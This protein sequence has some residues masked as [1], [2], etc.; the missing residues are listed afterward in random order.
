MVKIKHEWYGPTLSK[1]IL[2]IV[3][4]CYGPTLLW[5]DF[6]L[7][8]VIW[9]RSLHFLSLCSLSLHTF[10]LSS[11]FLS[12]LSLSLLCGQDREEQEQSK[13]KQIPPQHCNFSEFYNLSSCDETVN[14]GWQF[15]NIHRCHE[16]PKSP[17]ITEI[18]KK[19][20]EITTKC[21]EI[22]GTS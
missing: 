16:L 18:T 13:I 4:L 20:T 3:R 10:S 19:V 11:L 12:V 7:V 2:S 17:R 1:N 14:P 8:R 5:S 15:I 6:V 9:Q 22:T 21:T